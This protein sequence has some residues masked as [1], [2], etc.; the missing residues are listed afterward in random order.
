MVEEGINGGVYTQTDNTLKDLK[1]IRDFLYQ[2]FKNHPKYQKMLT[3]F[4]QPARNYRT[5]KIHKVLRISPY[6]N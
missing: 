2:N 6:N 3:T 4:N 1:T 5:A